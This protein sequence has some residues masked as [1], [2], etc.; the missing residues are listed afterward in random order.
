MLKLLGRATSANVQK[1]AWALAEMDVA[2]ERTDIGGAFGGNSEA[3][4]LKLNPTGTI[5]TLVDEGD[6]AVVWE[7]NTILRFL[8]NRLNWSALYPALPDAAA[9]A[10]VE[11]WMDWQLGT[12]NPGITPLFQALVR[13]PAAQ[14]QPTSIEQHRQRTAAAMTL[15]DGV[16]ARRFAD[17]GPFVCG[18]A[19]TLADIAL[20]PQVRRWYELPVLRTELPALARWYEHL[21]H[22]E[23]FRT[24][25]LSVP[26]S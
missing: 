4:Y 26:M 5:P 17:R 7:S 10:D 14:Q 16:L 9:R 2:F 21:T 20:G 15:L 25:V 1:V 22:R 23:A 11:R 8:A 24:H 12:L 13:T 3:P 18:E 19:F 6:G